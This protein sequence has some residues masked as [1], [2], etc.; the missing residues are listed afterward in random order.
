MSK[1]KRIV[2]MSMLLTLALTAVIWIGCEM[3][4][5]D[6]VGPREPLQPA[7]GP[8]PVTFGVD[9]VMAIQNRH[10]DRLLGIENVVGTATTR[11]A[12]GRYAIQ[13][14][15]KTSGAEDKLPKL[16]EGVPVIVVETGEIVAEA[17]PTDRIRPV[18]CGVSGNNIGMN[19]PGRNGVVC[20]AGTIGCVVTK[21]GESYF[22]SNNH[23]FAQTNRGVPGEKIVQPSPADH[24]VVC[25]QDDNDVVAYLSE[26]CEIK[27]NPLRNS[28]TIDAAIAKIK[29]GVEFT[30]AMVNNYF[31]PSS[32][33]AEAFIGMKLKKCGRTTGLTFGEVT[34]INATILVNYTLAG[35]ARFE[36]QIGY[37]KMNESGDSGSL[38]VTEDGNHPVALHFAGSSTGGFG[39]PIQAVLDYFGVTVCG[40]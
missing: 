24:E 31:T 20:Y 11:L 21:A 5:R 25:A 14:M 10:T 36:N 27:W 22:L 32:T 37:T 28:N 17:A 34:S 19:P 12:D 1:S 13:I 9:Q 29:P 40:N 30:C 23:V 2:L 3:G 26:F 16:L 8:S 6:L 18:P 38:I 7:I 15:V 4:R 35:Y 39:N 33:P